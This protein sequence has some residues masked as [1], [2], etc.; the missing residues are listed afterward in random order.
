VYD[1]TSICA[2]LEAKWNMPALTHRDANAH[3]MLDMLDLSK[4]AFRQPPKLA[5]PLV[6]TDP[7]ALLCTVTGPG[8]IP[9][10]G[11]VSPAP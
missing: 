2:L 4:A 9:P 3:P 10:A 1:H 5:K 7:R 6:E 11:S 8:T